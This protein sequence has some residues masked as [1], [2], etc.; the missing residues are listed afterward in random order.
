M[1]L[2]TKTILDKIESHALKS[3]LFDKVGT[4]EP[5]NPPGGKLTAAVWFQAV[6]PVPAGS[7][8]AATSAVITFMMRLYTSMVQEPQDLIDPALVA[9]ADVIL[10]DLSGDFHLGGNVR[11][12]DLLGQTGQALSAQAGYVTIGSTMYRVIDITIPCIVNDAWAQS[13]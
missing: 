3:G 1:S 4:H 5:K 8:L 6:G 10:E 7:G 12:I 13:A 2:G 11:N 9:A